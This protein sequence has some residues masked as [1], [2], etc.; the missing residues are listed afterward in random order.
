MIHQ[1]ARNWQLS[2]CPQLSR[3]LSARI[4]DNRSEKWYSEIVGLSFIP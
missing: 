4:N 1:T 2:I 3:R